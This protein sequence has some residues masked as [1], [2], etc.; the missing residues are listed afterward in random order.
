MARDNDSI[1][2]DGCGV[3]ILWA[4]VC[5][6]AR[7]FCCADCRDG[8]ACECGDRPELDARRRGT[9]EAVVTGLPEYGA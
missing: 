5:A 2:C 9:A 3:E 4:P 8:F 6:E 1:W 7:D